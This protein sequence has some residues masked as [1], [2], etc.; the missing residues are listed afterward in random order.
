[1]PYAPIPEPLLRQLEAID[2]SHDSGVEY[3]PCQVTLRDGRQVDCVY[4]LPFDTYIR[5]WGVTPEQDG[6]KASLAIDD[7]VAIS[8]SPSRLPAKLADR[9]YRAGESG[10]GYCTFSLKF[11]DGT[12]QRYTTGNAVDF[13][14][15][16]SGKMTGDAVDVVTHGAPWRKDDLASLQYHWCLY[17]GVAAAA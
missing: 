11:G 12:E 3:R 8:E 1:M 5:A 9:I 14:P 2:P 16:P 17:E 10:M 13:L 7:V 4:V 6:A 15:M